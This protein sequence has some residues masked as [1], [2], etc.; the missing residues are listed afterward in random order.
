MLL[1]EHNLTLTLVSSVLNYS[2]LLDTLA[3]ANR[4]LKNYEGQE[5]NLITLH[6]QLVQHK[7]IHQTG[8]TS[9][10]V[11]SLITTPLLGKNNT[12]SRVDGNS[13]NRKLKHVSNLLL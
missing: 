7:H 1:A 12:A 10:R 9:S 3:Q 11:D 2:G 13:V 6:A 5:Q 4:F 8:N